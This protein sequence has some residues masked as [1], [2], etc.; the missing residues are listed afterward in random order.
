MDLR[1]VLADIDQEVEA[2]RS[3]GELPADYEQQLDR[4]FARFA[5]V[6][7]VTGDFDTLVARLGESSTIDTRAPIESSRPG[8]AH[9]KTAVAKAIDWQL[10]HVATQASGLIH[11]T[12]R[13]LRLLGD[14]VDE[15]ERHVPTTTESALVALGP[16]ARLALPPG[17][18]APLVGAALDGVAGRVCH[19]ECGDGGLI[20]ALRRRGLDV[21]GVDPDEALVDG[22]V[23]DV[24]AESLGHHLRRLQPGA[25]GGLILSGYVDRAGGP[26]LLDLVDVARSVLSEK[27]RLVVL[28]HRPEAWGGPERAMAADL[29][30]GHPWHPGT[31]RLVLEQRGFA[32]VTVHA[33]APDGY[34]I[35]AAR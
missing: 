2:K 31:W 35:S 4:A 7:A 10:R 17:D 33:D 14:R 27:G 21:Y 18:W 5:P 32:A 8:V 13:A 22:E 23:A 15:L 24:R 12:S 25:L 3:S 16:A 20:V 26:A 34:A 28:S 19:A 29:S 11:A 9:I 6:D 1:R 30:G